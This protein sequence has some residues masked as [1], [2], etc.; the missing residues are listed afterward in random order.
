MQVAWRNG[1]APAQATRRGRSPPVDSPCHHVREDAGHT[2][3]CAFRHRAPF[4]STAPW[5]EVLDQ[6]RP[7]SWSAGLWNQEVPGGTGQVVPRCDR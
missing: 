7:P 5:V 1:R 2:Q 4:P 3:P 6:E